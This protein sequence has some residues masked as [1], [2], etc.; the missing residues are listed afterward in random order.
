MP[1]RNAPPVHPLD[2]Y[3]RKRSADR[4]TEPFGEAGAS[5]EPVE[6][7]P[8]RFVVQ[9]HAATRL[10]YDFRLE[11]GGVLVSWA[12]P[13]GPSL[14]PADKRLAVHV[15][16]HPVEYADFEGIIPEGNY[17]AGAVIVWDRGLWIP[18]DDPKTFEERGK[19]LFELKGH[20]L[21]GVWTL[22]RIKSS[23]KDWLLIKKPDGW[24]AA[25]G[26]RPLPQES[27]LSGLTLEDLAKGKNRA[28]EL[29]AELE[30]L[31]APHRRV[32]ASQVDLML[33]ESRDQPFSQKGWLFELKYDGFRLLAS[34]E[35]GKSRLLYRR[36]RD[37][38]ATFPDVAQAI[39]ALPF[40]R[41]VLDGEV[42]VL[43][44]QAR[45]SFQG[46]QQRVQ[47]TRAID[48]ARGAVEYPATFFAFDLL[49][50]EDFDV[51]PLP[52]ASRKEL[53]RK[54]LPSA[55]PVRFADHV[56]EQG[57]ALF[58]KIVGLRLEGIM[59]KQADSPYRGGRSPHWLKI[60]AE[61]TGDFVVVG[62]T[63]PERSRVGFGA[64]HLAVYEGGGFVYAGR[65]GTGFDTQQLTDIRAKLDRT[66]R[67]TPPCT[68][69]LP[70]GKGHVWVEPK[71]V[72]EVR[73]REWTKDKILR[74]PVFLRFRDDKKVEEC[75][76]EGMAPA[77]PPAAAKTEVPERKINFTHLDKVFWPKEGYTK[78]DL[79]EAYRQLSPWLL[80]YLHDRPVVLTRYPDGIDGK[81]FFQK[82]APGF[83]PGWIRTER[84]WSEHAQRE[85]DYF[86]CDDVESLLFLANLG[87]IPLHIWASRVKT[88]Q[89]PDWCI[90]DL[91]PKE[92]PFRH[93]VDVAKAI[94]RLC[95]EIDLPSFTKT[96]GST[97]LH[98]MI[99]LGGQLTYEQCKSLGEL[100]ARVIAEQLSDIATT[101]RMLGARNNRVYIDF[102]QNG[103]GKLLAAPFSVRP[104]PGALVSTP[105]E[106]REVNSKL[107]IH[108]F[109][110]RTVPKRMKRLGKDP[111]R[112]VLDAKPNLL[113]ALAR[114]QKRV[115]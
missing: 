9:K 24:A 48:I 20:K 23:K 94:H 45:P 55:G 104:V 40:D 79:I 18:L 53:L 47:L 78:G 67:P 26:K 89:R 33:A 72:C 12:I 35:D 6:A 4:T 96:S 80:P 91:D 87:T 28:A 92:A 99:P 74:M 77:P 85:I 95:D 36:G 13:H 115:K 106:W 69:P 37:S 51:R 102:L 64:L 83:V 31:G 105:L 111:L 49:G 29:R 50:F 60:R 58:E 62:Y 54:M 68:G 76:R 38:T 70:P 19:L 66:R 46:L 109:T 17:G 101:A 113:G 30:R 57:E 14:D 52:L 86:V 3:R 88:L 1:A 73:F 110:I 107:D 7:R 22:V 21:R 97:G 82:D 108:E 59:A 90:L 2:T 43:D 42:T 32:L 98:V 34:R 103:H 93:V 100:M 5:P 81:S 10:H 71:L 114:L 44:D 15:E 27:I 8:G 84:M 61:R 112:P 56:D 63:Q 25:A 11:M 75:V 41:F 16:D 65:A 39:A